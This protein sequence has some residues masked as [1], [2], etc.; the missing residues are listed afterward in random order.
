MGLPTLMIKGMFKFPEGSN[1]SDDDKKLLSMR[2]IDAICRILLNK[3]EHASLLDRFYILRAFTG[4]GKSTVLPPE[5]YKQ[6]LGKYDRGMLMAEPRVNLCDNGINDIRNYYKQWQLG[7]ELAIHTGQ[8]RVSS[9]RRAFIEF[10][11]TQVIQNFLD[12]IFTAE[13]DGNM[14]KVKQLLKKYVVIVIDEAHILEIQTI[15]VIQSVK[16]VLMKYSEDKDCPLFVF[17][18]ATLSERQILEY[19]NTTADLK[20]VMGIVK[21]VPNN[22]IAINSLSSTLVEKINSSGATNT[23]F[24]LDEPKLTGGFEKKKNVYEEVGLFFYLHLY[25]PLFNSTAKVWIDEYNRE[26]Q[27]RDALIFVPGLAMI[28]TI[29]R[30]LNQS[31][32]DKPV[33]PLW[34]ETKEDELVKWRK[35]NAKKM[36][37]L[38]MGYSADYSS[39]SLQLLENPYELDEDVLEYETKI[40]ISTSV[41]E[42]GKT[43]QLL[44]LCVDCGY[45]TKTIYNPLT[46]NYRN[47]YLLKIPANQ[48]QIT[49][50]KGRV[51]RKA[52]GVFLMMYTKET[53]NALMQNDLPETIN[54]G[55][56]SELI[57]I[58]QLSKIVKPNRI[59]I[60]NMNDFLYPISSDLLIR[61]MNDLFW[62][63]LIGCNGEW[64]CEQTD[65][66]WMIYARLAYYLLKMPLFLAIMTA[67][68]NQY[69]LPSVYQISNFNASVFFYDFDKCIKERYVKAAEFIPQGR[70][71]FLDIVTG[72]SKVIV[73]YRN[74]VY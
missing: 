67:A 1:L 22:P 25:K 47:N 55:C 46:F 51:G 66:R 2:P 13:Q 23:E 57:Y 72:K 69:K 68:I 12:G 9:R 37:V 18:S 24:V 38:V 5:T 61:S 27:C 15:N 10:A 7:E 11:T 49:Q 31:I 41:I 74:D 35:E 54:S 34:R 58:T 14:R 32:R 62:G 71:L 29:I 48:S 65:V 17:A 33:F 20:Y 30:T 52:A 6:I 43:L 64:L 50:R 26:F 4:A 16:K 60:C 8:K 59:E 3:L 70:R 63:N 53:F 73:P 44:R 56:L 21:G 45:N 28:Q 39:L 40:I 36:R 19:F 42:T